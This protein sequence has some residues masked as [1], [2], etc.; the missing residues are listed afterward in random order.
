MRKNSN[1]SNR[2]TLNLFYCM[3]AQR[4]KTREK[5]LKMKLNL[6]MS[7]I[8]PTKVLEE[9]QT[10]NDL[11][12]MRKYVSL[13]RHHMRLSLKCKMLN[14]R[15]SSRI[16]SKSLIFHRLCQIVQ[17]FMWRISQIKNNTQPHLRNQ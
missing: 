16:T 11:R 14:L 8:S 5:R 15:W 9:L 17:T 6:L 13:Y 7:I 1:Y 4:K 3:K 2:M 10:E 12:T